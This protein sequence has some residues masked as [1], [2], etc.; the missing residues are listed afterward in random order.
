MNGLVAKSFSLAESGTPPPFRASRM[1]MASSSSSAYHHLISALD[2]SPM[3]DSKASLVSERLQFMAP[4]LVIAESIWSW[5]HLAS[6]GTLAP[7]NSSLPSRYSVKPWSRRVVTDE[8]S[9]WKM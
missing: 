5:V 1:P 9:P 3:S 2:S 7:S 6:S 4:D 8:V